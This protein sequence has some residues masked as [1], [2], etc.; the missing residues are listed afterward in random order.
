MIPNYLDE[1]EAAQKAYPEE[2][3][4]AHVDG[5]PKKHDF[6]VLLARRLYKQNPRVGCNGKRGD[7]RNLSMDALNILDPDDGPGNTPQ[8]HRCWVVDV[9]KDAGLPTAKA[10]WQAFSDP[11]ASTGAWVHPMGVMLEP[12]PPEPPKPSPP[13]PPAITKGE[14]HALL[15]ALNAFYAAPEGLQRPGGLVIYDGE[16]R[17]IADTEA[18]AQWFY[19]LV[20]ERVPLQDVITQIKGSHEWRSKHP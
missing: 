6:I 3:A 4:A 18:M 14:A 19:Q 13:P 1:V 20:V 12:E 7:P 9:I 10:V 15:N 8:G 16:G 5:H 2:W 17:A 11:V